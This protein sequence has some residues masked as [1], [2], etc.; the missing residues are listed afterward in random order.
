MLNHRSSLLAA[1]F[2]LAMLPATYASDGAPRKK[3][4]INQENLAK[5]SPADQDRA[6]CIAERLETIANTDR[7]SLTSDERK[8]LRA[9]ARGLKQEADLFNRDGTVIYFSAGTLIIILLL[10]LIL[11]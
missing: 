1:S 8:A 4:L 11:T 6:L 5:L 3:V 9:E 7:S 10:I 2:F